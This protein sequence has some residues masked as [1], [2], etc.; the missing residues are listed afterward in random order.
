MPT[1]STNSTNLYDD[2][3]SPATRAAAAGIAD[4]PHQ[5]YS[6]MRMADLTF[7]ALTGDREA[8]EPLPTPTTTASASVTPPPSPALALD[9]KQVITHAPGKF[10]PLPSAPS[11]SAPCS[12]TDEEWR[13]LPP[14]SLSLALAG[15]PYLHQFDA[16]W[17]RT[18]RDVRLVEGGEGVG[19]GE[20]AILLWAGE[21][22]V[23]KDEEEAGERVRMWEGK[24]REGQ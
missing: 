22:L 12:L 19:E 15:H 18:Y 3:Y 24:G 4:L 20:E 9:P 1:N 21:W 23:F 8:G 6:G 11:P 14:F 10:T 2:N 16:R 5:I 7:A 17:G 13:Q